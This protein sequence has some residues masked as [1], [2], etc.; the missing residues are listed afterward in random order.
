MSAFRWLFEVFYPEIGRCNGSPIEPAEKVAP[1]FIGKH[2]INELGGLRARLRWHTTNRYLC[3]TH[4]GWAVTG[5]EGFAATLLLQFVYVKEKKIPD[6]Y[7]FRITDSGTDWYQSW[8]SFKPINHL[9][10][11][12]WLGAFKEESRACPYK[13]VRDSSCPPGTCKLLCSSTAALP[14]S[15]KSCTGFYIAEQLCGSQLYVGHGA[16]RDAA[17][18]EIVVL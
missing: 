13:V 7:T 10:F 12:G 6:T 3:I 1:A 4:D 15:Q 9:R 2:R 8:L 16:D 11:G 17:L 5:D 14:P 18:L